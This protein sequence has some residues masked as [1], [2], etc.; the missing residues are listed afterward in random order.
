MAV[1]TYKWRL[2]TSRNQHQLGM[3]L[4]AFNLNSNPPTIYAIAIKTTSQGG[5]GKAPT[6]INSAVNE[7]KKYLASEKLDDDLGIIAANLHTD[8]TYKESFLKWY[9]P[10]TQEVPA[11]K[12]NLVPVPAIVVDQ[13]NWKDEYASSVISYDFGMPAQVRILCIYELESLV[14]QVYT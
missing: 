4:L 3:D 13:N 5:D 14:N 11:A 1:L 9:A 7:L 8:D 2:N 12:P 6:V 10:Y